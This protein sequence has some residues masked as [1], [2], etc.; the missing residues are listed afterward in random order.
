MYK[1]LLAALALITI[2]LVAGCEDEKGGWTAVITDTHGKPIRY[3]KVCVWSEPVDPANPTQSVADIGHAWERGEIPMHGWFFISDN[4]GS[5]RCKGFPTGH[6]VVDSYTPGRVIFEG[7]YGTVHG[8][9][10]GGRWGRR[11]YRD[12][13]TVYIPPRVRAHYKPGDWL[14]VTI[15]AP[16]YQ[17]YHFAFH[18]ETRNG[19]LGVIQLFADEP[20]PK[21]THD[22]PK[23]EL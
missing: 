19:D 17:P 12:D 4:K 2:L 7:G 22:T 6:E 18:P 14:A 15:T 5:V 16:G 11:V 9:W 13:H 8:Y 3:A 21:E 1:W 23:R 20:A 10:E